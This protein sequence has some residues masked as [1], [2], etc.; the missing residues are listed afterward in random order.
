MLTVPAHTEIDGLT[1]FA[2]DSEFWRFY[3][4]PQGPRLRT[5]AAGLPVFLLLGYQLS[6]EDRARHPELP[7]GGGYV[8]FDTVLDPTDAQLAAATAVLQAEVDARWHALS[9]GTPEERA[10]PG[11]AGTTEPPALAWGTPT[12]TAG[13]VTMDAPQSQQLVSARVASGTPTLLAG[14]VASFDLDLTPSGFSLLDQ[15]LTAG[16]D[17]TPI[18]VAYDLT[19]WA[20]LP[21]ASIHME[22]DADRMHDYLRKQLQGRGTDDCTTYDYDHSDVTQESLTLSGAVKVQIDT[23]SGS[24]PDAVV[25][26]LRGYAFDT[27]KQLVQSTFFTPASAQPRPGRAAP[28]PG[29]TILLK[30]LDHATMSVTLDLEQSS[31]VAWQVH[32]RGMLTDVVG[33][34]PESRARCVKK[35]ALDDPFFSDV[36]TEVRVFADFTQLDHVEVELAHDGVRADGSARHEDTV[37]SFVSTDAQRWSVPRFQDQG[38]YRWRFRVVRHGGEAGEWSD[39]ETSVRDRLLLSVPTP[40]QIAVD[41]LAGNVDFANLVASVQVTFS[42]ADPDAHVPDAQ[43][44]VALTKATPSGRYARAVGVPLTRPVRYRLRFDLLTGDVVDDGVWHDLAGTQLVVNQPTESV[45]RVSLLPTGNRWGDV[46]AVFVDLEHRDADGHVTAAT[47]PLRS[48]KEFA[49]WQVYL[50]DRADRAYRYRWTASFADGD[51][52]RIDWAT[53]P[54]DPVLPVTL[55]RHGVDVVVVPDAV[56]FAAWPLAEVALA[57]SGGSPSTT[58]LFRDRTP[59]TWHLDAP[60]PQYTATVTYYPAGGAPVRADPV[61]ETDAV[62]VIPAHPQRAGLLVVQVLGN[63]VDFAATPLVGVDLA[64]DDDARGVHATQSLTLDAAA[65]TATWTTPVPDAAAAGYRYRI[66]WFAPDGTPSAGEWTP[67]AIPRIVVPSHH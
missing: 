61:A 6:D 35:V 34:T 44:V 56:D 30:D 36:S 45:L 41:V 9:N 24:L 2:D 38:D 49:S 12:W 13:Q 27:L 26:S 22:I 7:A 14:N 16:Q 18:E 63:L 54:G 52:D 11:V 65:P 1:I 62:L 42:Y 19:L 67:T 28:D 17:P 25:E 51:S 29:G 46:V 66:T 32:P 58:L 48:L 57:A 10:R 60:A 20:R 5:D 53:S 8:S 39:W 47:I 50:K 64:F 15:T 21:P 40:G 59:Q 55:M 23:G 3:P 4:V 43:G 37:L 31:V 33:G